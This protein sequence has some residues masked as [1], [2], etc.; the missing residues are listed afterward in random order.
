[1]E[2]GN[3]LKDEVRRKA[4]HTTGLLVPLVYT[5]AGRDYTLMFIGIA[6]F[7]FII[8]E[9]FRIIEEL[10]DSVKSKLKLYVDEELLSPMEAFEKLA[11]EIA[12]EEERSRVATHIYFAVASFIVVYFF[13]RNIA[14][15]AITVATIGDALAAIIGKTLGR[16]RFSNGKSLE[17]S[18]AY[19]ITGLAIL[20]PLM[21]LLPALIGAT[22]GMIA[23]FYDFPP[24]DNFSNQLIVA[25]VSY[26]TGWLI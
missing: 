8:L 3:E 23:E 19:L 26:L 11:D 20:T 7:L 21:G 6:L 5:I 2:R 4:L 13:P 1:M 15:G 25:F 18:L 24:D 16:H 22:A 9:P 10:R 12:R 14:I 17:G